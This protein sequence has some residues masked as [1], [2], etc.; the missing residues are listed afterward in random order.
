MT[1]EITTLE[2][3]LRIIS[4]DMPHLESTSLGVWV[5]AGTRAE[6]PDQ[7]GLAHLL[8][9]MAFKGTHTRSARQIAEEIEAVGGELNAATSIESTSYYARVLKDDVPLAVDILADILQNSTFDETELERE[10]D[11]ILQ[12]IKACEDSPDDVVFD[13]TQSTAYADQAIGRPILGTAETIGQMRS[14][15]LF[16]YMTQNYTA[17][18]MIVGAAGAISHKALVDLV[19]TKFAKLTSTKKEKL[20]S[21]QYYGGQNLSDQS[22]EQSHV[23]LAFEGFEYRHKDYYAAQV[24]SV[25]LGGGMSSRL[26]QEVREK[27]G[28]CYAIYSFCWGLSDTGLF[29]I[30]AATGPEHVT[31]MLDVITRELKKI[32]KDGPSTRELDRAKVQI[33][34]GLLMGL[35]SS[36]TRSEQLA[37]QLLV[38]NKP[39][40]NDELIAKIDTVSVEWI[41]NLVKEMTTHSSPTFCGAGPMTSLPPY[42]TLKDSLRVS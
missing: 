42:E 2:N 25:L 3:G 15:Q 20:Q 13:L 11:V 33:K 26:F 5:N 30:H 40:S 31:Q 14:S 29:G 9:H 34:A 27:H 28:L 21:A 39:V 18:N 6:K 36:V 32:A 10:K 35:E 8:E 41:Q 17:D 38:F 4:Q 19:A 16:G 24:L 23:V 7:H 12:E 1:I 22:F 37:R